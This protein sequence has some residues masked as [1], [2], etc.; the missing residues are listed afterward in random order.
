MRQYAVHVLAVCPS[1]VAAATIDDDGSDGS[2]S[3]LPS[4]NADS[5]KRRAAWRLLR[6]PCTDDIS[7]ER[8]EEGWP[9]SDQ[10]KGGCVNLVLTRGREEGLNSRKITRRHMYMPLK[11]LRCYGA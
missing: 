2:C 10:R 1:S 6:G 9:K 3:S 11:F 7:R 8:E 4:R 5:E